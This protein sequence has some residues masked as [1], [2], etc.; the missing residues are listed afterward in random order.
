MSNNPNTDK[1]T[2][3]A[4]LFAALLTILLAVIYFLIEAYIKDSSWKGFLQGISGNIIATT[5]S[6]LVVYIF[7]I[8]VNAFGDSKKNNSYQRISNR[9]DSV[10]NLFE[11]EILP[12]IENKLDLDNNSSFENKF[13]SLKSDLVS[14]LNQIG[15]E[16]EMR[17]STGLDSF[18]LDSNELYRFYGLLGTRMGMTFQNFRVSRD[19]NSKN[20]NAVSHLW[21]DSLYGNSVS[22][23]IV[24]EKNE[25]FL[26]IDFQS[27]ENSLGC[28]VTIRPQDQKAIDRNSNNSANYLTLQARIPT[29]VLHDDS[30]SKFKMVTSNT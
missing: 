8:R 28:N 13:D 12:R 21:A 30:N 1:D 9:V 2:Y 7:I 26:R 22:A 19:F 25:T 14:Q 6:F 29:E 3:V 4:A 10:I 11:N 18:D 20:T 16:I 23:N 5:V 24:N 27:F 17:V 15:Q